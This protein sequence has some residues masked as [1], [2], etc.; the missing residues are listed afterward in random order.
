[1]K[2]HIS[3]SLLEG[4]I[5]LQILKFFFPV[6]LGTFFQQLYN[7]LDAIVVGRACGKIALAAVGGSTSTSIC[8]L[9]NFI[10][11]LSSGA[12]VIIAQ[13]YGQN[14]QKSVA[15]AVNSGMFLAILSGGI[16]MILGLFLS[17][18][19]LNMLHVTA[20]VYPLSLI[21]MRIFFCGFIPSMIYNVGSSVLRAMGDSRT[22]LNCLIICC[23]VNIVLDILFV[24]I[25]NLNVAGAALATILSQLISAFLI[26][27]ILFSK[28]SEFHFSLDFRLV[29]FKMLAKICLIGLP[30]GIQSIM[31]SVAN[32]FIQATVNSCGTDTMA[33]YTAFGKIDAL[34]WN[35][36]GA[37]GTA[38]LTIVGQNFGAGKIDRVKKTVR[39]SLIMLAVTTVLMATFIY[40]GGPYISLLFTDDPAVISIC[41]E[42]IHFLCP[43][44]ILFNYVEIMSVSLR[45]C[46]HSFYPMLITT[47]FICIYR[48]I[49]LTV[50]PANNIIESLYCYPISWALAS[51]FLAA[52]YYSGIWYK[53]NKRVSS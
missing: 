24:G 8:L 19:L 11:G 14:D 23:I 35:I 26:Y 44:W 4:P 27:F 2:K 48:I 43:C 30:M 22:P 39:A 46:G 37:F 13:L 38:A 49:W 47:I 16:M 9:I 40:F 34:Y 20:D 42:F 53:K 45:A 21:Y 7:T 41:M 31:Y 25:C 3:N 1:M 50:Y 10:T 18:V 15:K 51:V 28:Y 52:Y 6:M 29:D 33:A 32:L 12:T 36:D 5:P 17:P